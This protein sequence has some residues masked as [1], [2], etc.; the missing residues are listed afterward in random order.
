MGGAFT[1]LSDDEATLYYNPAGISSFEETRFIAGYH[2][3]FIDMQSGFLGIITNLDERFSLGGS[4]SYLNYG[5]FTKTDTAGNVLGDFSGG[6]LVA[7]V[8]LAFKQNYN[9]SFGGTMKFIYETVHDSTAT[10][11][12]LDAGLKYTSD[13]GRFGVG[14]MIQN[15][16]TQLSA[17][18]STKDR[19]PLTVRGGMFYRPM[20]YKFTI[21]G[22]VIVPTDNSIV[23]AAGIDYYEF[24]PLYLRLGWNSFGSNFRSSLSNDS[25]AGLSLGFG[26]DIKKLHIAYSFSPGAELGESHRVTLTGGM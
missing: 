19:L 1:G 6:S 16:G 23:V 12:A 4:I 25:W 9:L 7:A 15:L 20:G 11:V 3:Y 21:A 10:G 17:L 14:A 24:K 5:T 13:R 18:G 8:T 26:V 2:N 22:D